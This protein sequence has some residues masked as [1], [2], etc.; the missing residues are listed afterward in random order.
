MPNSPA[1]S[2]KARNLGAELRSLRQVAKIPYRDMAVRLGLP[3]TRYQRWESGEVV[4]SPEEV[5]EFLN[6]ANVNGP[7]RDRILDLARDVD[8]E[9]WITSDVTGVRT[10]LT[11]LIEFERT[12]TSI[13]DVSPLLVPGPLQ[14]AGYV[15]AIMTGM[16]MDDVDRRVGIRLGR[17]DVI[18]RR[19]SGIPYVAIIGEWALREPIGGPDVMAEQLH[20]L[21]ELSNRHNI[22]IRVLPHGASAGHAAHMGAFV[23]FEFSKAPPIVHL[24]HYGSAAFVY[25]AKEVAS[26]QRAGEF[27]R[28][29]A[30]SESHSRAFIAEVATEM[31]KDESK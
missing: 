30:L 24:E 3:P 18:T 15:R 22:E 21:A 9:N 19:K 11:T 4:P 28:D 12:C 13:L 14:T 23:L 27:L 29:A 16:G 6:Q 25:G 20:R 10:E 2:P 31:E 7:E 5:A 1:G 17:Q 26:Y 8:G